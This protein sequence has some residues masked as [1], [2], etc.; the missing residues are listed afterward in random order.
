MASAYDEDFLRAYA[1]ILLPNLQR[2]WPETSFS[3]A[4]GPGRTL[5]LDWQDGPHWGEVDQVLEDLESQGCIPGL[6][7]TDGGGDFYCVPRGG[8]YPRISPDR[9]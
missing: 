8:S 6:G 4:F 2:L 5:L 1:A 7:C 9:D 3:W